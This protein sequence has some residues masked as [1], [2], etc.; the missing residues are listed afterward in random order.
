MGGAGLHLSSLTRGQGDACARPKSSIFRTPEA[1]ATYRRE[2]RE[3]DLQR[4][5]SCE[6]IAH[7]TAAWKEDR[8]AGASPTCS[9]PSLKPGGSDPCGA[10]FAQQLEATARIARHTP[11][12]LTDLVR[13]AGNRSVRE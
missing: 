9:K 2:L 6:R 11:V 10:P 5:G 13:D 3:V 7:K 8:E 1:Y 12:L 4:A